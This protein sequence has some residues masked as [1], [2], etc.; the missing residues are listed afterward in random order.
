MKRSLISFTLLAV[1]AVGVSAATGTGSLTL[2]GTLE[3]SISIQITAPG[4]SLTGDAANP[5]MALGSVSR[6][7]AA[8]AGFDLQRGTSDYTLTSQ[9]GIKVL[10]EGAQ[11]GSNAMYGLTAT[12]QNPTILKWKLDGVQL[13]AGTPVSLTGPAFPGV[14]FGSD[15]LPYSFSVT[16]LNDTAPTNPIN[17]TINFT[18][19]SQ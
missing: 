17:N 9:S 7:G 19:T 16:I 18:A 5:T 1:M 11:V 3:P 15:Q 14:P 8:P 13:A 10:V 2:T 4:H 6:F 12:L